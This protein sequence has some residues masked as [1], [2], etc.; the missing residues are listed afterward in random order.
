MIDDT[1][2]E[3]GQFTPVVVGADETGVTTYHRQTGHYRI[4][5]G[6]LE[7]YIH[8]ELSGHSGSGETYIKGLPFVL[9][10]EGEKK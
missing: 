8:V 7:L 2:F 4:I 5:D 9:G 3:Q 1:E 6:R 10:K